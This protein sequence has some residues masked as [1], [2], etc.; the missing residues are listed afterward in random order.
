MQMTKLD[1]TPSMIPTMTVIVAVLAVSFALAPLAIAASWGSNYPMEIIRA[2]TSYQVV[3]P[4]T[5]STGLGV[6]GNR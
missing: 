4:I 5:T 2:H 6:H 3:D 1:S